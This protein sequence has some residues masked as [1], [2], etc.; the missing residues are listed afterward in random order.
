[1]IRVIIE[2]ELVFPYKISM[3]VLAEF[4]SLWDSVILS[5]GTKKIKA[6]ISMPG[7]HFKKIFGQNPREIS[8]EVPSGMGHFIESLKVKTVMVK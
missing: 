7:I 4:C 3:G 1:M 6:V 8:Y 2:L 5:G